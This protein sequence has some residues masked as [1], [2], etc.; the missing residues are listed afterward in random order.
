MKK[1]YFLFVL[2]IAGI[3]IHAQNTCST[4]YLFNSGSTYTDTLVTGYPNTDTTNDYG[5]LYTVDNAKWLYFKV[6]HSG[7]M[8]IT[9]SSTGPGGS[10]NDVDFVA[11]GPLSSPT[12][13]GLTA[14]Q[15]VDCSY[16]TSFTENIDLTGLVAGQYYKIMIDNYSNASG[17]LTYSQ[18]SGLATGCDS[19]AI[20]CN[21]LPAQQICQVTTDPTTNHNTIIWNK[22][23][24]YTNSYT[25]E[26]ETTTM[27]VYA[28]IGTVAYSDTSVFT[29]T[30]SN[31]LVQAFKYRIGT[32]DN[33]SNIA[34]GAAHQTIH[35]L[36]SASTFSGD[37]QLA[38][39]PYVGFSY[40]TYY[41]YRGST[42]SSLTLYDSIA[43]SSTTYTDVN[44]M[45]GIAY[46]AVSVRPPTPCHP[47]RSF[48]ISRVFSNAS[49]AL[50]TGITEES[51]SDL[52]ISPNPA[53]NE[54]SFS[55]ES[56][57]F[58]TIN[59]E[60]YDITGRRLIGQ[61]YENTY[62]ATIDVSNLANGYYVA[63][64]VTEKGA[65]QRT[66]IIAK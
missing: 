24:A 28:A 50:F 21:T 53:T 64:F 35:L 34:T 19:S 36:V 3:S 40:G 22:D 49:Y 32:I 61:R 18:T 65:T 5:C 52:V 16:S 27:G 2:L 38:W 51:F 1:I 4:P 48:S 60:I 10:G 26:K 45:M 47:T 23:P 54:I 17:T 14:S 55:T 13:C 62:K 7:D 6:C 15:I 12:D 29:D 59:F 31:A 43:A 11:W 44:P 42:T 63:R 58:N 9:V 30:V 46:Y 56:N 57:H 33:C 37:P 39:N 41:I 20:I 8:H 66:V 25:I